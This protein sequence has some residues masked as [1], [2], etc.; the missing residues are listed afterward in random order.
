ME[1]EYRVIVIVLDKVIILILTSYI[2][3]FIQNYTWT[4]VA[5]NIDTGVEILV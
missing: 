3:T 1:K 2:R 5:V 4:K